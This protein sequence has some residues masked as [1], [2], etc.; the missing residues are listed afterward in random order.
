MAPKQKKTAVPAAQEIRAKAE[1]SALRKHFDAYNVAMRK[2]QDSQGNK[3]AP[4]P[5]LFR[6]ATLAA[7]EP[8]VF[9]S[10]GAVYKLFVRALAKGAVDPIAIAGRRPSPPS[11]PIVRELASADEMAERSALKLRMEF[12]L[13][14]FYDLHTPDYV[15]S[16]KALFRNALG[17]GTDWKTTS[18]IWEQIKVVLCA[19]ALI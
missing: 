13:Q 6:I 11:P 14:E 19:R 18:R 3:A 8:V 10:V 2:Y 15:S 12:V 5:I 16:M 4:K 1:K 9:K 17:R 7:A